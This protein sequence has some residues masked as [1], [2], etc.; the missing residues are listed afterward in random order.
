MNVNIPEWTVLSET[1]IQNATDEELKQF[2][3]DFFGEK[4]K[5]M[6]FAVRSSASCED[7]V[8]HSFAGLFE[9][10]LNISFD[11]LPEV[12][13]EINKSKESKRVQTYLSNKEIEEEVHVNVIVQEL[14]DAD[15]SGVAFGR[16]PLKKG[17][18]TKVIK[19]SFWIR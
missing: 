9:S 2:V 7:G 17:S 1:K 13:R 8:Q 15:V 10:K 16:H 14:I 5:S 4:A 19:C 6:F 3:L 12:I 18:K 11:N